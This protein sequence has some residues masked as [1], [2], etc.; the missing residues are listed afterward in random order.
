MTDVRGTE[1]KNFF[2]R[3][4]FNNLKENPFTYI[5]ESKEVFDFLNELWI[6]NFERIGFKE[7]PHQIFNYLQK[8]NKNN[9]KVI[10]EEIQKI[11]DSNK[12]FK[13]YAR[14]SRRHSAKMSF[15]FDLV[16]EFIDNKKTFLDFGCGKM[17]LLRRLAKEELLDKVYY[18]Y[19]PNVELEYYDFHSNVKFISNKQEL[20]KIH[21]V[22]IAY[23]SFVLHHLSAE[24]IKS[25]LTLIHS[26]LKPEGKLIVIEESFYRNNVNYLKSPLLEF[27]NIVFK[28][29]EKLNNY[30]FKLSTKEKFLS[31]YLND[32][33]NNLKNLHYMPWTLEYK[34][35]EEWRSIIESKGF[36][37]EKE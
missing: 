20:L 34:S 3:E 17:A 27:N 22:D 15:Q 32:V 37:L 8:N 24:E 7:I 12:E 28:Q 16:K 29:N 4:E 6:F 13:R 1:F 9:T 23:T 21:K 19:D 26:I 18:G 35:M 2:N 36:K 10:A 14:R 25:S 30:F 5:L 31:I 11:I 33:L